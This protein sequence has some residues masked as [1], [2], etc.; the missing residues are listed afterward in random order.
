MSTFRASPEVSVT[1]FASSFANSASS[2]SVGPRF[3]FVDEDLSNTASGDGARSSICNWD[4]YG[5]VLE[6]AEESRTG[7]YWA[8]S[9]SSSSCTPRS[10]S[11]SSSSP[12]S[13]PLSSP[14]SSP[15]PVGTNAKCERHS[16]QGCSSGYSL[17]A[18]CSAMLNI[19]STA[20]AAY[21]KVLNSAIFC[22][23]ACTTH[24]YQDPDR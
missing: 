5:R 21:S 20:T 22:L 15:S 18:F 4:L 6:A 16:I 11:S 2:S 12:L 8:C 10:F 24:Y 7:E 17:P 1:S 13:S 23:T 3:S 14:P 9:S 19:S